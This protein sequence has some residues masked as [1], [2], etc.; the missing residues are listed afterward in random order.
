ME[1][2]IVVEFHAIKRVGAPSGTGQKTIAAQLE[3]GKRRCRIAKS[4]HGLIAA[5]LA[6]T[7]GIIEEQDFTAPPASLQDLAPSVV[8]VLQNRNKR[9]L[10]R[11]AGGYR[12]ESLAGSSLR[13]CTPAAFVGGD[14][15]DDFHRHDNGTNTQNDKEF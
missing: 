11:I 7:I 2:G 8:F 9:N 5:A 13:Q 4:N 10:R 1:H 3:L 6:N 12:L 15:H 14:Q